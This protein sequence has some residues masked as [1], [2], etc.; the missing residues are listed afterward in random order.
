MFCRESNSVSSSPQHLVALRCRRGAGHH[1]HAACAG[2]IR[3]PLLPGRHRQQNQLGSGEGGGGAAHVPGRARSSR[4]DRLA[5]RRHVRAPAAAAGA[6][7][8][9]S[10]AQRQRAVG[11]RLPGASAPRRRPSPVRLDVGERRVDLTDEH[12]LALH[13]LAE[14]RAEQSQADA[15]SLHRATEDHLAIGINGGFGWNDEGALPNVWGYIVEYGE[16]RSPCLPHLH[17]GWR[18]L[19]P[20]RRADLRSC[21]RR[22]SSIRARR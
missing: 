1:F 13:E 17:G 18:R 4:D 10:L 16:A 9:A 3:R 8:S 7:R 15:R 21:R 5:R 2:A 11:R 20:D 14:R 22:P 12:R 19:Q 6:E